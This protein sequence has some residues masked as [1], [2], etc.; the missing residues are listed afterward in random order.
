MP[1]STDASMIRAV[2]VLVVR[3]EELLADDVDDPEGLLLGEV[4]QEE[5]RDDVHGLAVSERRVVRR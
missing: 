5:G 3:G 1:S 4:D 2:M